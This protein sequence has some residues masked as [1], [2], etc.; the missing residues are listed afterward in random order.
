[1]SNNRCGAYLDDS[2]KSWVLD[3]TTSK[4]SIKIKSS[5]SS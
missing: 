5:S 4:L 3:E 2:G 1:M